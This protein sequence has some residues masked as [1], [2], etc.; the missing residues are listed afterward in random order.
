MLKYKYTKSAVGTVKLV[1]QGDVLL[2]LLWDNDCPS[3][4]R[5]AAME[6]KSDDAFLQMVEGE[7]HEY[8]AGKRSE[9]SCALHVSGTSFQEEVWRVLQEIP[10]GKTWTY[11]AVAQK[12]GRPKAVRAVGAA[13]GRNPISI[14][15]P[16]HRVLATTGKLQGFAGGLDYKQTL[17][18]IEARHIF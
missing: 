6:E 9:F 12:I 4:V 15:I 17:L 18:D 5:L 14:I 7:L 11:K 8:L 3:R 2:A 16:C 13:I 10:Y 1:A